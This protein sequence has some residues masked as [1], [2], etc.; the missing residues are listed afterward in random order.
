MSF[1]LFVYYCALCGAWAA[2]GGWLFGEWM[3]E[4]FKNPMAEAI[5]KGGFLGFFVSLGLGFVDALMNLTLGRIVL[6]LMRVAVAV[7]VGTVGGMIGG[8][9]GQ[10][11][12]NLTGKEFFRIIGWMLVGL[13]IGA[14]IGVFDVM[15][16]ILNQEDMR[17]AVRKIMNGLLGGTVGGF[18]GG[19]VSA[20]LGSTASNMFEAPRELLWSPSATGF[21]ALGMCIGLL[22]GLAHV[23]LKEAWL[24]VETGRRAGKE[25]IISKPILTIGRAEACDLGL[26]GYQGIERMHARIIQQGDEYLIE[27]LGTP[28]GT[29]LN[30]RRIQGPTPLRS[31][32]AIRVGNCVLRFG[33]RHKR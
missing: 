32:D 29:F 19:I 4:K 27:D 14:S 18:V 30:D 11:L 8:M 7:L 20:L 9:I 1:R 24:R 25:L 6:I 33:E 3:T 17:G 5:V 31:G 2:L 28:G 13:L 15:S 22:I 23:I 16:R 12:F 26:F 10:L 21:V